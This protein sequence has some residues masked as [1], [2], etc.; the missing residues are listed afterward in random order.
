MQEFSAEVLLAERVDT[1]VLISGERSA[2][3]ELIARQIHAGSRRCS[4]PFVVLHCSGLT[5]DSIES[6]LFGRMPEFGTPPTTGCL[7]DAN[8]GSLLIDE[9][10][11]LSCRVQERML[12]FLEQPRSLVRDAGRVADV[13]ILAATTENLHARVVDGTFLE[14]LFYRLNVIHLTP[15][16][17]VADGATDGTESDDASPFIAHPHQVSK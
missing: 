3:S 9:I 16:A 10:G 13:R 15:P 14:A 1:H 6:A 12:Q 7:V 4:A 2:D 5:D 17:R 11:E 8:G